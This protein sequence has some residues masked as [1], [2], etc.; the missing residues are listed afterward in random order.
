MSP[1]TQHTN[2]TTKSHQCRMGQPHTWTPILN[3]RPV[4]SN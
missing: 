4:E 2:P 3:K 1:T